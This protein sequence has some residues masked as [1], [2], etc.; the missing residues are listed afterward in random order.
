M[1]KNNKAR[2]VVH[3]AMVADKVIQIQ[4]LRAS[5][6][7]GKHDPRTKRERTRATAKAAALKDW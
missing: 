5:G 2:R 3:A 4:N 6:A 7:A 1:K